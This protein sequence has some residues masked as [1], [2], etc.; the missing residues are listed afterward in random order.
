MSKIPD[1]NTNTWYFTGLDSIDSS[2]D[3]VSWTDGSIQRQ[4]VF[5]TSS[6][7]LR[8]SPFDQDGQSS[9]MALPMGSFTASGTDV[10]A[11]TFTDGSSQRIAV[12]AGASLS[13][14]AG[15]ICVWESGDLGAS[16][17]QTCST[18]RP[19]PATNPSNHDIVGVNLA[20]TNVVQ[21]YFRN[22][23]AGLSRVRRTGTNTYS[24]H[25]DFSVPSQIQ[26][27]IF[28]I[29]SQ[30]SGKIELGIIGSNNTIYTSRIL[31]TD[32][33]ATWSAR[34]A[35]PGGA[36]PSTSPAALAAAKYHGTDFNNNPYTRTSL[37]LLGSNLGLYSISTTDDSGT[38][39]TSWTGPQ[40]SPS[41]FVGALGAVT[42]TTGDALRTVR[43]FVPA[44]YPTWT[45]QEYYNL[46][47]VWS[48]R[49]HI[50]V[51][52]DPVGVGNSNLSVAETSAVADTSLALMTSTD[53]NYPGSWLVRLRGS[54]DGANTYDSSDSVISPFDTGAYLTDSTAGTG[55][56]LLHHTT[57]E[58]VFSNGCNVGAPVSSDKIVYRRG[59]STT[60]VAALNQTGSNA[61]LIDS[62]PDSFDH[63]WEVVT[64]DLS[65]ATTHVVYL[66]FHNSGQHCSSSGSMCYWKLAPGDVQ[67]GPTLLNQ[68][69]AKA[70]RAV[71]GANGE[72]YAYSDIKSASWTHICTLKNAFSGGVQ[73]GDCTTLA[74]GQNPPPNEGGGNYV[75]VGPPL[76]PYPIGLV[77]KLTST[78]TMYKCFD[79]YGLTALTADPVTNY[80]VYSAYVVKQG[81]DGHG[82]L[83]SSAIYF[84][85]S[86]GG[87]SWGNWT[88]PIPVTPTNSAVYYDPTITVDTD[89][90]IFV[91][92][93]L[94]SASTYN[95]P[96]ETGNA[97]LYMRMS[98]DGGATWSAPVGWSNWNTSSIQY[99]CSRGVYFM[100]E[101]RSGS[102]L[103]NR[104]Y[105]PYQYG[106]STT[107][108]YQYRGHW[109]SRWTISN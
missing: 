12:A 67:S 19:L 16:W 71:R 74:G 59:S 108:P 2:I 85:R 61:Y 34:A 93:S 103:G 41:G 46:F 26:P 109:M 1:L 43:L 9:T 3:A 98:T 58:V 51:Q 53:R 77:C 21:F 55:G 94:F 23:F 76:S 80:K 31:P 92:Y 104:A 8:M 35:L 83:T 57:E 50:K 101:Y 10:A 56:G 27:S 107:S 89:G 64:S 39:G 62:G 72:I 15:Y 48:F 100:G 52:N 37:F 22:L 96:N 28:A 36:T 65:G 4:R 87:A 78:D 66:G 40:Y 32:A 45:L 63:P 24:A 7:I 97:T 82:F 86:T 6:G 84:S 49:D 99:H 75:Y 33:S 54:S 42:T 17:S 38:W 88:T 30:V 60:A 73:Q 13:G 91:T 69:D 81:D 44:G 95:S 106:G 47:G 5:Y 102:V 29:E 11:V 90:T 68:L 25:E 79:F 105:L 18:D 70:P 14:T 20:G